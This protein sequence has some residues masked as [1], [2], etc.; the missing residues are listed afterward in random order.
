M[1]K[2]V[3]EKLYVPRYIPSP[4]YVRK[5]SQ[6][7][8]APKLPDIKSSEEIDKMR[9]SCALARKILDELAR[10]LK[11]IFAILQL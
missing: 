1:P 3:S 8:V 4:P 5:T 6:R 11:V 9:K 10:N 7:D 2:I